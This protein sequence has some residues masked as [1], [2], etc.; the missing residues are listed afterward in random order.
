MAVSYQLIRDRLDSRLSRDDAFEVL[1]DIAALGATDESEANV[2]DLVIRALAIE[3]QLVPNVS[4]LH[5]LARQYGLFPYLA[6]ERLQ[7]SELVALE[8]HRASDTS[9]VIF[10]RVQARVYRDLV[11][12]RNVILSAPTSFGKTFILDSILELPHHKNIVLLVPTI[13]LIDEIRRRVAGRSNFR[14][15]THPGQVHGERNLFVLTQERFLAMDEIPKLDFFFVDEFYKAGSDDS[16][17]QLLNQAIY[18]LLRTGAQF[19]MAGPSIQSLSDLLPSSFQA[20]FIK[21]DFATVAADVIRVQA[22]NDKERQARLAEIL[23]QAHGPTLI[24]CKSPRRARAVAAWVLESRAGNHVTVGRGMIGQAA[25]WIEQ[26]FG[27]NWY[28]PDALRMGVGVHHGR[29]PRWLNQWVV[30]GFEAGELDVLICTSTLIEGVNTAAKNVVVLDKSIGSK[31]YDFFTFANIKGRSGRMGRHFVGRVFTFHDAPVAELPAIDMPGVSQSE[32]A[33]EGLL[34]AIEEDDRTPRTVERLASIVGQDLLPVAILR[35]NSAVEPDQQLAFA[36]GIHALP[37]SRVKNLQW[38]SGFPSWDEKLQVFELLWEL[39]PPQQLQS[40]TATSAKHLAFLVNALAQAEGDIAAAAQN[41][42]KDGADWD[43]NIER[44]FDFK[45][46]W[47]E[48]HL[49]ARL[50]VADRICNYVLERRGQRAGS[51]V[52]YAARLEAGFL[53]PAILTVEEYGIPSQ[54]TKKLVHHLSERD[55]LDGVLSGI[56]GL[57]LEQI[58][59]LSEFEIRVVSDASRSF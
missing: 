24:Y 49:P 54:I 45:R 52:A 14:I 15:I 3:A 36:A 12:G 42:A 41:V 33:S 50:R 58:Q 22:S 39:M 30:R 27:K 47:I 17:A 1:A 43:E 55:S 4:L 10:H 28:V 59:A 56:A 35:E 18:R 29:L 13:A 44:A 21:T 57:D 51:F 48:H 19:Y 53:G 6:A 37:L 38:S 11:A 5:S 25:D 8:A 23:L 20:A 26:F 40:H 46:F 16:R 2:R 9:G 34:L 7:L 31:A 32:D